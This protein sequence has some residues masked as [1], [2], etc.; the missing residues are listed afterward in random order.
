MRNYLDPRR[1]YKSSDGRHAS[2][3]V[4]VGT[5]VEGNGIAGSSARL[6][7]KERRANLTEEVMGDE[8]VQKYLKRKQGEI[9]VTNSSGNKHWK[10]QQQDRKYR[11]KAF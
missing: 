10:Q 9:Q 4:Q 6:T 11:K 1:F 3:V 7:K 2:G 8:K 5:I